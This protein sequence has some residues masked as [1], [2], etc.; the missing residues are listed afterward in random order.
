MIKLIKRNKGTLKQIEKY[1]STRRLTVVKRTM[2]FKLIYR[3]N[4]V[5]KAISH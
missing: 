2:L 5:P 1:S 3:L 4:T